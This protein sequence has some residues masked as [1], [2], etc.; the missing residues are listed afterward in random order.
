MHGTEI[1]DIINFIVYQ[2]MFNVTFRANGSF[3]Y[4]LQTMHAV[5]LLLHSEIKHV[6]QTEI[7]KQ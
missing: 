1:A 6:I 2:K 7:L 4:C 5:L 3:D